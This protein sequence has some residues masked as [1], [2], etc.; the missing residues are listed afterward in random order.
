M[1]FRIYGSLMLE[2]LQ[3][4]G[5]IAQARQELRGRGISFTESLFRSRLRRLHLVRG[6]AVGDHV[7]SWDVL[8]TLTW[9][10]SHLQRDEPIL[11]IGCYASEVILALHK[12][13]YSNLTGIDLNPHLEYMPYSNSIRYVHGDFM[14]TQFE[15][16]SF[17]AVTSISVIQHGYDR[18]ALLKE[19]SRLLAPGGFFIASFDYWPEKIDTSGVRFFDMD[20]MIFSTQDVDRLVDEAREYGLFPAGELHH[21]SHEKAI[22]FGGRKYTFGWL[23]LQKAART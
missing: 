10:E 11:D 5:Q 4:K 8:S 19:T 3:N 12:L 14:H 23:V 18:Q 6:I 17:K 2:V 15:S 9:I 7:K 20:W 1:T 13:G 16:G 22:D 21:N